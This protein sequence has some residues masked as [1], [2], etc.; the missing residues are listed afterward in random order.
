MYHMP[1]GL[2]G[3]YVTTD[4]VI[5][6]T[7]RMCPKEITPSKT[8]CLISFTRH[9]EHI[10]GIVPEVQHRAQLDL[11]TYLYRLLDIL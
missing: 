4:I 1:V 3:N 8:T 11:S 7:E 2:C 5:K 9:R 10:I 6:I